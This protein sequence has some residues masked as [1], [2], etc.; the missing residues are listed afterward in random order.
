MITT[1]SS[2]NNNMSK[3]S[4]KTLSGFKKDQFAF[5]YRF[6]LKKSA[7][8]TAIYTILLFLSYPLLVYNETTEVAK[9]YAED[10]FDRMNYLMNYHTVNAFCVSALMCGMVLVFSAVL[11]SYMHNK[12]SA[13]FFHS[14]PVDRSIMLIANFAAGLTNLVVPIWLNSLLAA[15]A[16]PILLPKLDAGKIFQVM[17]AEVLA[18]TAGA[19]ILLAISTLVAVTVSTA[20]EN[21][22]YTVA[23]LLEGSIL[24]LIWDM[25]CSNVFDTYL[26]IFDSSRITAAWGDLLYYLSPV[27]ALG[28]T[29]VAAV[30]NNWN[31]PRLV[32]ATNDWLPLVLWLLLSVGALYLAICQYNKRQSERAEQWGRQSW[33]G[34]A[35][36]LMSAVIGAFLFAVT[37]GDTLNLEPQLIYIF[38]ALTGAPI[39][40]M[41]IE[42]ITNKG[43]HNMQKC[44]PYV[45]AAMGIIFVFSL[46]FAVDGF[47]YDEK[48]PKVSEVKT[49]NLEISHFDL[50]EKHTDEYAEKFDGDYDNARDYVY[51]TQLLE[52]KEEETIELI[53]D[54]HNTTLGREGEYLGYGRV[55]YQGGL[56]DTNRSLDI[57]GGNSDNLLKLYHSD[58]YLEK[59]N[60]FFELKS[61]YLSFVQI[62]DKLG[63]SIGNGE[64]PAEKW[65]ELLQAIRD[66]L[67]NAEPE[68]LRNTDS[69][70]ELAELAFVTKYPKEIYEQ[71]GERYHYDTMVRYRVRISDTNTRLLLEELGI[72]LTVQDTALESLL[73]AQIS[74]AYRNSSGP[75]MS[76]YA[77]A[78]VLERYEYYVNE[79]EIQDSELLKKAAN[80]MTSV[81]SG[82]GDQY[83]LVLYRKNVIENEVLVHE[84][85]V[86][87]KVI[88]EIMAESDTYYA[89]Y[90]LNNEES[91]RI[92]AEV[93]TASKEVLEAS[94]EPVVEEYVSWEMALSLENTISLK[95]Y[96]Q[97]NFPEIL[98]GKTAAELECMEHTPFLNE[99][100]KRLHIS[101]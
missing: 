96:L 44:L 86:D 74:Q 101:F 17:G 78:G 72:E 64:I 68:T 39:T 20:V 91:E 81:Y 5:L 70:V 71:Y 11:Y 29:I 59:Y 3:N 88:A 52:F 7:G 45:G 89:P 50:P 48:I 34:F 54:I 67:K 1:M 60:P 38:G 15:L 95:A 6:A 28:R 57:R 76:N 69:N 22:G 49:V 63:V 14:M 36:K 43:F 40:Y 47:G 93:E 27:F 10:Y 8:W 51:D 79:F 13:D 12:R 9:R 73:S 24:L 55:S 30:G 16:Y 42:A 19:F 26:S 75:G 100:G 37:L 98:E 92:G 4:N 94:I 65:D 90:I 58:E 82:Y 23:L 53:T 62:S 31:H 2:S 32:L 18:W 46:Y 21:V 87:R 99:E 97:E 41:I 61:E 33:L 77:G 83:M 84:Y 85:Y 35:V 56:I 80:G 25:A 66:D